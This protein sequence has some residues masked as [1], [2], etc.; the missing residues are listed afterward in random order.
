[1][2]A[3]ENDE[4]IDHRVETSTDATGVLRHGSRI[5]IATFRNRG[6]G[7]CSNLWDC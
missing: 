5:F 3:S 2:I 6:G 1:M 4:A 7:F